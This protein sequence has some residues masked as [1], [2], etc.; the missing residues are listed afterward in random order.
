MPTP[1]HFSR[2]GGKKSKSCHLPY[3]RHQSVCTFRCVWARQSGLIDHTAGRSGQRRWCRFVFFQTF[4][5]I[6]YT[7]FCPISEIDRFNALACCLLPTNAATTAPSCVTST[8]LCHWGCIWP[9]QPYRAVH[10]PTAAAATLGRWPSSS[11]AKQQQSSRSSSTGCR[12]RQS[13]PWQPQHQRVPTTPGTAACK[14]LQ[15]GRQAAATSAAAAWGKPAATA[16]AEAA[17]RTAP[18]KPTATIREYSPRLGR[19][20]GSFETRP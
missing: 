5:C 7:I 12:K 8:T 2:H 11:G 19:A 16:A 14:Q 10:R 9:R 4:V 3:S 13:P 6:V 15:P 17:A 20:A 1:F 18:D